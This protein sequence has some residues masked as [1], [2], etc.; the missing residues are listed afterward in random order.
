MISSKKPFLVRSTAVVML[1]LVGMTGVLPTSLGLP[2]AGVESV[3]AAHDLVIRDGAAYAAKYVSQS[4]LDPI[5]MQAGETKTVEVVFRNMGTAT[6]KASGARALAAFTVEPKYRVSP[7]QAAGWVAKDQPG[8][9][10]ADVAPGKTGKLLLKLTAPDKPGVYTEKFH[11]AAE[12]Y[13]W[14][15]GG[16]FFVKI[17]V[18]PKSVTSPTAPAPSTSAPT[19]VSTNAYNASRMATSIKTV[20]TVGGEQVRVTV[21]Y[22]NT[23]TAP[24]KNYSVHS[25][26]PAV[27][28][29][30]TSLSFADAEWVNAS[31]V[32]NKTTEV[33]PGEV[34]RETFFFRAPRKQGNYVAS[35]TLQA[36]GK[37]F[38]ETEARIDVNVTADA[39]AHYV[40]P[41]AGSAV[42]SLPADVPRMQEEPRIR[43][44]VWKPT[45][46]VQFRS[47]D[48]EYTVFDGENA[49]AVLPIGRVATLTYSAGTY[50]FTADG[51][52]VTSKSYIRLQPVNNPRS[53]FALVN[54]EKK[55]TW[56]GPNNFNTYRGAMEYR[57]AKDG[58]T[59]YAINDLL[60]EDYVAGIAETS[61]F[62]PVEYI[63]ALLVA[64]RTYA[65]Y[66]Q[67]YSTKHDS[68]HFDVMSD[69]SDQ[70]YLGYESERL[71]PRVAQAARDTR[72]YMITYD[73]DQNPAT[74][75]DIVIT[76]YFANT[77][78]RTR[79]WTEVWGGSHKPWLV[80]VPAV[81]DKRE[82]KRLFGHGVGMSA[83]DAAYKAEEEGADWQ[84]LVKYYYTG[85][86][87]SKIYE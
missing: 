22:K 54:Q 52:S 18:K 60:M 73:T 3:S 31:L 24:W 80:S 48:D 10:A 17:D 62:V 34:V 15:K 55:V 70:L 43:V 68:R 42:P 28:A 13:S 64:A 86:E 30:L 83:L 77:D 21:V 8:K 1:T 19:P 9:I 49:V 85:V 75:T 32:T 57:M 46:A 81:Y 79:A 84:S 36:D 72:G 63:K 76:P 26:A 12:N 4:V 50:T 23:G 41:H 56:K 27:V 16:Y 14:V 35:F 39:P 11:L 6:W 38:S 78:G 44:G 51:I 7:F 61:N 45:G 82:N 5:P 69:T 47:N 33:Q 65:H 20:S 71:M 59:M 29:G 58:K 87:I 25:N 74:M 66:I 40:E 53:I 37:T 2:V 67:D